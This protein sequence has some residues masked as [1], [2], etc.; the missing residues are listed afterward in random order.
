M[1]TMLPCRPLL[2]HGGV[3]KS[4]LKLLNEAG[5][6]IGASA[7]DDERIPAIVGVDA[8]IAPCLQE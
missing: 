1:L 8:D 5:F 3:N 4:W 6:S 2:S 7:L